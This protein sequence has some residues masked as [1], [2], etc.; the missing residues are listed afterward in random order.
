MSRLVYRLKTS[1]VLW[2]CG[3]SGTN[4]LE[5]ALN[6]G[7]NSTKK[8]PR[9]RRENE[10]CDRRGKKS[11]ILGGPAEGGP[12]RGGPAEGRSSGGVVNPCPKK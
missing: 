7:D 11:D 12:T 3:W 1:A 5:M 6:S 4:T 10:I 8:I 9:E 2:Q